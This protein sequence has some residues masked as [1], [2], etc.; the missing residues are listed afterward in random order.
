MGDPLKHAPKSTFLKLENGTVWP[1]H[2]SDVEWRLRYAP[3]RGAELSGASVCDAYR[4][5]INMPQRERNKIISELR[6]RPLLPPP[7]GAWEDEMADGRS[8]FRRWW[9]KRVC[10]ISRHRGVLAGN[11]YIYLH[12]FKRRITIERMESGFRAASPT[13]WED[14]Q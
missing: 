3:D 2:E 13:A 6:K 4:T 9:N 10:F 5:L 12:I 11:T 14:G 8:R 1:D 7:G